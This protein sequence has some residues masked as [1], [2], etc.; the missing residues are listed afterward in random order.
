M[1]HSL[2]S[3]LILLDNLIEKGEYQEAKELINTLETWEQ[4]DI[5]E[6][7]EVKQRKI[8]IL[9]D[10]GEYNEAE[11]LLMKSE[12][13]CIR[14]CDLS[15][16]MDFSILKADLL[17]YQSK[18]QEAKEQ[19]LRTE[20]L[21]E[22]RKL[23]INEYELK[24]AKLLRLKATTFRVTGDKNIIEFSFNKSLE[25]CLKIKN[26]FELANTLDT[27]AMYFMN[28]DKKKSLEYLTRS[29]EIR[30]KIKNTIY[31]A[32]TY[33]RFAILQYSL[34]NKEKSL[35]YYQKALAIAENVNHKEMIGLLSM[36]IANCYVNK[37]LLVEA[38]DY[39]KTGLRMFN[40]LK[41]E[42]H[43]S[44][45]YYN[46]SKVYLLR[47]EIDLALR[48]LEIALEFFQ[49]LGQKSPIAACKTTIGITYF[50]RGY[51][52]KAKEFLKDGLRISKDIK[53]K[54]GQARA[55]LYLIRILL[56]NNNLLQATKYL[57]LLEDLLVNEDSQDL[58]DFYKVSE[59]LI[60]KIGDRFQT[61]AKAEQLFKSI[62]GNEKVDIE[63]KI[64]AT[65]GLLELL[66]DE[67][68]ITGNNELL[69]ELQSIVDQ[70]ISLAKKQ[71]SFYLLVQSYWFQSQ[72]A[73]LELDN[74]KSKQYLIQ[75]L[76]ISE[77]NKLNH[78]ISKINLE[79]D[80]LIEQS[81]SWKKL[82]EMGVP[83][84]ER[85]A[86]TSIQK[87]FFPPSLGFQ[88]N[89]EEEEAVYLLILD[90]NGRN[91]FSHKFMS[92]TKLDGS[93]IGG[94]LAAINSFIAEIFETS[95]HIERIKHKDFTLIIKVEQSLLFTYVY[96]GESFDALTK[97][98][99]FIERIKSSNLI[100]NA[101]QETVRSPQV[102]S[103][104]FNMEI[105]KRAISI[106]A[107]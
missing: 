16:K 61:K 62:I 8:K 86:F 72:L 28:S 43:I 42:Y 47:G 88:K 37:G 91:I 35:E 13:L 100:W 20:A 5:L 40:I 78:L 30:K 58:S 22:N 44:G 50:Q 32:K 105:E 6:S 63:L 59:A 38:L 2:D 92:M 95:G 34:N 77:E 97:L 68:K 81:E 83:I 21:L 73:V 107:K 67:L 36:N 1:E 26:N 33:N 65:I 56:E 25:L 80:K 69:I 39:Y 79:Y 12:S 66:I 11:N 29:L 75:A 101:L 10:L 27:F 49:K 82:D 104:P 24:K 98:N 94:F 52:E 46:L 103:E 70:L 53:N 23:E 57:E 17:I 45:C 19:I 54:R 41:N 64:I 71:H 90:K 9:L 96:K 55:I 87:N 102:L 51:L 60:L 31:L 76:L 84:K 48:N 74:K 3:E 106:F 89:I 93:L 18:Y 4:L 14:Y 85:F 99:T 7:L 15:S